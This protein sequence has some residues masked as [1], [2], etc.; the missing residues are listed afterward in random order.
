MRRCV[1]SEE[2]PA[3]CFHTFLTTFA[4]FYCRRSCAL[5]RWSAFFPLTCTELVKSVSSQVT[6]S[7]GQGQ[8]QRSLTAPQCSYY[9][10][11]TLSALPLHPPTPVPPFLSSYSA[12]CR[13]A[14]FILA[15]LSIIVL[16]HAK[17]AWIHTAYKLQNAQVE[18]MPTTQSIK[19]MEGKKLCL[20]RGWRFSWTEPANSAWELQVWVAFLGM[21][22][23][24]HDK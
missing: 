13:A 7:Q 21:C 15:Y 23:G 22:C 12:P 14:R 19:H 3:W 1:L 10:W 4:G 16:C 17:Q 11:P 20:R 24:L 9:A 2:L 6:L 18:W 5:L 8:T